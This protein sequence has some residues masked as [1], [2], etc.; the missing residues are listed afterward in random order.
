MSI[1]SQPHVSVKKA[2]AWLSLASGVFG[3][4]LSQATTVQIQT[5]MG[6]IVVNLFDKTTPITVQ[7]FLGYVNSGAYNNTIIHR[8]VDDFII[9]GGG[10]SYDGSLPPSSIDRG[11]AITN[12]PLYSNVRGT[13]TMAKIGYADSQTNKF[14]YL[15]DSA[16]SEWFINTTDNSTQLDSKD[17]GAF[18]VFGQVISGMDVV[19]AIQAVNRFNMG[20]PFASIPLRNYSYNDYSQ[21]VTLTGDNFVMVTGVVVLDANPGTADGL[22]PTPNKLVNKK[23][24]GGSGSSGSLILA[25]LGLLAAARWS[26]RG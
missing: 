6:D 20:S 7:N 4:S 19:D 16:T 15:L 24:S 18:T 26:K 12:E 22:S 25:L 13:I 10:Y 5:V 11:D 2:L 3:A 23:D 14:I 17:H 8:T 21:N 9:Q 1:F